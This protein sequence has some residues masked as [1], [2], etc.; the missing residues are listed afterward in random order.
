L[1][2]RIVKPNP[3]SE[4]ITPERCYILETWNDDSDPNVSIVRARVAPAVQTQLHALDDVDERYIVVAG[5]GAMLVGD[6]PP[7]PVGPGDVVV[8]PA[9]T[10]QSISNVGRDDLVFYCVCSPRFR[11]EAYRALS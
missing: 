2:A 10:P 7:T 1:N 11:P 9:G 3:R 4:F 6:L 8:I 5:E